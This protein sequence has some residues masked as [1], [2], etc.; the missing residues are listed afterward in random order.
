MLDRAKAMVAVIQER[1]VSYTGR[2]LP[3]F[4]DPATA[5]CEK[6][7]F[8]RATRLQGYMMAF[9]AIPA[10]D[11]DQVTLCILECEESVSEQVVH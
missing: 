10:Q 11:V 5:M 3:I 8:Y 6:Q 7:F 2:A 9:D 4:C 1:V